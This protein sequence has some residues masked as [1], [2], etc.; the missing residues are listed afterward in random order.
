MLHNNDGCPVYAGGADGYYSDFEEATCPTCIYVTAK[1]VEAWDWGF[2]WGCV[3]GLVAVATDEG[4]W[5]LQTKAME[6][7]A[8]ARDEGGLGSPDLA[9]SE[10]HLQLLAEAD[11]DGRSAE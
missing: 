4:P 11:D 1:T 8:A 10:L 9:L 5:Y 3:K 2:A 6:V 7:V